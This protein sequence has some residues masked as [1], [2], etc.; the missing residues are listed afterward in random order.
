MRYNDV[1][2]VQQLKAG[3]RIYLQPK[4]NNGDVKT[5]TVMEGE[6][7]FS[8]SQLHGIQLDKLYEKNM[9]RTRTEPAIGEAI[10]LRDTRDS[11][12]KLIGDSS[13]N[14]NIAAV[15]PSNTSK[16]FY[17]VSK[18]DTLFSISKNIT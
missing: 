8:I 5:H 16:Q 6:T 3:D 17:T 7:M 15:T 4:R 12:P 9:M 18:G 2:N 1:T 14:Q 10:S 13:M 11:A